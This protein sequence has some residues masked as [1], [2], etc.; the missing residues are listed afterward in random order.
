MGK[1]N[2][3]P[4]A[5]FTM[6]E[7]M[8]VMVLMVLVYA[9]VVPKISSALPGTELKSAAREL[10]AGLRKARSQAITH[11]EEATLTL[12]VEQH[13]FEISGDD[14]SYAV[15]PRLDISLYTAQSELS[16]DKV[17]AIRFYP[18]GSSTGGRISV[19]FGERKYQVDVDW[20]T[21]Q[22]TILD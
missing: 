1:L 3:R 7:L 8:V 10:A 2:L 13:H 22:V 16:Q 5:G 14:H 18:D 11:K 4:S 6:L 17:G 12:D 15:S 19:S 21:G 20:L 9:I